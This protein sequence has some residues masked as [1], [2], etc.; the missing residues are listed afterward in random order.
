[1]PTHSN[2]SS[3]RVS[4]E[5]VWVINSR[6][7]SGGDMS[8]KRQENFW[9]QHFLQGISNADSLFCWQG[10]AAKDLLQVSVNEFL[11]EENLGMVQNESC[12]KALCWSFQHPGTIWFQTIQLISCLC[13]SY[14]STLGF[15]PSHIWRKLLL[16]LR[17]LPGEVRLCREINCI[18]YHIPAVWKKTLKPLKPGRK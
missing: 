2:R 4:V 16:Q 5:S 3:V 8:G 11:I 9:P 10:K 18:N 17:Y 7:D 6:Y 1:M 12:S 15:S 13:S 14:L